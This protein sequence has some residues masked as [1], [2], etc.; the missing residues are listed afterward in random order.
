M[1]D[2]PVYLLLL[3]SGIERQRFAD[4]VAALSRVM[5]RL[6]GCYLAMAPAPMQEQFGHNEAPQSVLLSH[7]PSLAALRGFWNSPKYRSIARQRK[8]SG[9]LLAVALD[10]TYPTAES[11]QPDAVLAL[12]LGAGPSPALLEAAGAR[13]LTLVRERQIEPLEGNWRHGDVAIY[14]WPSAQAARQQ[15]VAFSSGQRGRAL[16]VPALLPS[17]GGAR[18]ADAAAAETSVAA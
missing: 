5:S 4:Y 2:G 18:Q 8:G 9:E 3:A 7:W 11:R 14:G 12:F 13:A 6:G 15:L 17:H 10:A 16:L 1:A